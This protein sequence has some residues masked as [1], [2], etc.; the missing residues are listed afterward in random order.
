MGPP[1]LQQPG[2]D[3]GYQS[4][5]PVE[6]ADR[7]DDDVY[8]STAPKWSLEQEKALLEAAETGGVGYARGG[9]VRGYAG[10]GEVADDGRSPLGQVLDYTRK[11]FGLHQIGQPRTGYAEGGEVIDAGTPELLAKYER[12][13]AARGG[14]D[15][16]YS[17][18]RPSPD[19]EARRE[20]L[21]Y[22]YGNSLTAEREPT[23]IEAAPPPE[24]ARGVPPPDEARGV[25]P[26][27]EARA[28]PPEEAQAGERS[29]EVWPEPT[30]N[31]VVPTTTRL[32][33]GGG[34]FGPALTIPVR[35]GD[36][37]GPWAPLTAESGIVPLLGGA[38]QRLVSNVGSGVADVARGAA[39]VVGDVASS[40]ADAASRRYGSLK[41]ALAAYARGERGHPPEKIQQAIRDTEAANPN[42]SHNDTIQEIF[43]NFMSRNDFDGASRTVQALRQPY[44]QARAI[45]QAAMA[46][47]NIDA[48]VKAFEHAHNLIPNDT[49]VKGAVTPEGNVTLAATGKDGRVTSYELPPEKFKE[50]LDNGH[51]DQ[52]AEKGVPGTLGATGATASAAPAASQT[53]YRAQAPAQRVDWRD[54]RPVVP[55]NK[56]DRGFLTSRG[57]YTDRVGGNPLNLADPT[58]RAE[59]VNRYRD[60]DRAL[61]A[62]GTAD[63]FVPAIKYDVG[64]GPFGG[65]APTPVAPGS[66]LPPKA[67]AWLKY[68]YA[69][70]G[71]ERKEYQATLEGQIAQEMLE[72]GK[73]WQRQAAQDLLERGTPWGTQ[74]RKEDLPPEPAATAAD[75]ARAMY[76]SQQEKRKAYQ[77]QLEGQEGKDTIEREKLRSAERRAAITGEGRQAIQTQKDEAAYKRALLASNDRTVRSD[78]LR[79][80][81]IMNNLTRG[82]DAAQRSNMDF[83]RSQVATTG[84]VPKG[85]EGFLTDAL[86]RAELGGY[87]WWKELQREGPAQQQPAPPAQTAPA[88]AAPGTLRSAQGARGPVA[89]GQ[90]A[91]AAPVAPQAGAGPVKVAS[92]EE[93][94]RLPRGTQFVGPDGILR[95]VP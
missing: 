2:G 88:P 67:Q 47:G 24:E 54:E 16:A 94:R 91:A 21:R 4:G 38:A 26:P 42:G 6:E 18:E 48:A 30:P 46:Q 17:D 89:P 69:S 73:P 60:V 5:G 72:R 58:R 36:Q 87:E 43:D 1:A 9:L 22:S 39:G 12:Q 61:R 68:P 95:I 10:G 93:A 45:G 84:Q 28:L 44:D 74:V 20:R 59:R 31:D 19:E 52:M 80:N 71:A 57:T 50:L 14:V 8:S 3:T 34:R 51:F 78:V 86:K 62:S 29:S 83:I 56:R 82:M 35:Q 75:R 79:N 92:P 85:Y 49:S 27:E 64:E 23:T 76:P 66:G 11:Q 7:E 70:Q 13:R 40:A 25:P 65:G 53:G 32:Q 15:Y 90:P 81:N 37:Y 63:Y 33:V 77:Q 55:A 41:D